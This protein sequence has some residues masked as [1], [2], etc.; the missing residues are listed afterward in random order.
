MKINIMISDEMNAHRLKRFLLS[1]FITI[2]FIL[3]GPSLS[4]AADS[5]ELQ[6]DAAKVAFDT[7]RSREGKFSVSIPTGWRRIE[8]YPYKIDDT[9]SGIIDLKIGRAHV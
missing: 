7:F 5:N 3:L 6:A 8:S 2:P 1:F 4:L 9:V